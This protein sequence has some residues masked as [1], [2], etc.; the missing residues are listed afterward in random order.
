MRG[1]CPNAWCRTITHCKEVYMQALVAA[2]HKA[3]PKYLYDYWVIIDGGC[4]FRLS[5]WRG[6]NLQILQKEKHRERI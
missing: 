3:P 5:R 4:R 6:F 1:N 2:A